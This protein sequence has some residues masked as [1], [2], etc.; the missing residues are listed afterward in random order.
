MK[1]GGHIPD[2]YGDPG[3]GGN[4]IDGEKWPDNGYIL[5]VKQTGLDI[6][7]DGKK[8]EKE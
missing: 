2:D 5:K 7:C 4:S 1:Q 8:H 6:R 3:E